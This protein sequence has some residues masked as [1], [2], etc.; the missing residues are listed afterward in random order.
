MRRPTPIKLV[1]AALMSALPAHAVAAH[2]A[3][4]TMG[5]QSLA[6]VSI[7]ISIRIAPR[8]TVTEAEP[9]PAAGDGIAMPVLVAANAANLRYSIEARPVAFNRLS[10]GDGLPIDEARLIVVVPD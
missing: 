1:L 3:Q 4:G 7:S 6:D 9:A 8:F 10:D 2:P 5:P